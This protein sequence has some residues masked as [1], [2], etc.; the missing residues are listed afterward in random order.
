MKAMR[1]DDWLMSIWRDER[2]RSRLIL[3]LSLAGKLICGLFKLL[4]GAFC[5]SGW[6]IG[7]GVYDAMPDKY[8]DRRAVNAAMIGIS[9]HMMITSSR[10][11]ESERGDRLG[12]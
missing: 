11:I 12:N 3:N 7:L 6:M 10:A 5:S 2:Q 1:N 9:S 8:P 4:T